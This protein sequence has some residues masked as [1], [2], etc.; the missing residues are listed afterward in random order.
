MRFPR[1]EN[2]SRVL[3]FP[4][5]GDLPDQGLNQHLRAGGFCLLACFFFFFLLLTDEG[6][7][8]VWGPTFSLRTEKK[9]NF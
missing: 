5:A 2:W 6:T 7:V 8:E 1:Q 3:T 9:D 4:Y